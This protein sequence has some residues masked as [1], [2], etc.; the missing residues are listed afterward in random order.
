MAAIA[1]LSGKSIATNL[2]WL[3]RRS[4]APLL[5]GRRKARRARLSALGSAPEAGP[6]TP[7]KFGKGTDNPPIKNAY[8]NAFWGARFF[9]SNAKKSQTKHFARFLTRTTITQN[10]QPP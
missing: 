1:G 10:P 3:G 9:H 4:P 7:I 6:S 8:K 2:R 5:A